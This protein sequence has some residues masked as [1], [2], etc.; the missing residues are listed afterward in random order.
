MDSVFGNASLQREHVAPKH[1]VV[2]HF[3][4]KYWREMLEWKHGVISTDIL[5]DCVVVLFDFGNVLIT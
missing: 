2:D 4:H 1:G 5:F 3:D